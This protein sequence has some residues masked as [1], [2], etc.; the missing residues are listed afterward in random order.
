[1]KFLL[2]E[3]VPKSL[4]KFLKE[5]E[6][7]VDTLQSLKKQGISNGKV[8]EL[9]LKINAIILTF[10]QDF[11]LLSKDLQS[12]SRVIYIKIHPRDPKIAL[13]LLKKYLNDAISILTKPDTVKITL[14][15]I[16]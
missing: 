11:T 8:A 13:D 5:E 10:D 6:Y 1:M 12:K 4:G 16:E 3:N 2:D 15:G 14:K 9:A 7:E